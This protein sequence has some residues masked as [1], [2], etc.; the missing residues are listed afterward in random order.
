MSRIAGKRETFSIQRALFSALLVLTAC[1]KPMPYAISSGDADC[2]AVGIVR[3]NVPGRVAPVILG[4][5]DCEVFSAVYDDDKI[6]DWKSVLDPKVEGYLKFMTGCLSQHLTYDGHSA[7]ATLQ[8]IPLGAGGGGL[9]TF[10]S[11]D[12]SHWSRKR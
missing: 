2:F 3:M 8:R 9:V 5:E 1:S 12:G 10:V 7:R 4:L 6:V 11:T